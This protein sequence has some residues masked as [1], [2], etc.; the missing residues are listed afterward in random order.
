MH[1]ALFNNGIMYIVIA[2]YVKRDGP[3]SQDSDLWIKIK[4]RI[5]TQGMNDII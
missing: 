2:I 4:I 5:K 1:I 3:H